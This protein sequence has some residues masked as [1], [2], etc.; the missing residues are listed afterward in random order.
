MLQQLA[1]GV[2]A[3]NKHE[4][5][6][7]TNSDAVVGYIPP[8]N[9]PMIEDYYLESRSLV[10]VTKDAT[11]DATLGSANYADGKLTYSFT[12]PRTT[13]VILFVLLHAL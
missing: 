9:S 5:H 4:F 13:S 6:S 3:S 10:G 11:N 8:S 1:N 7:Q 12:R 2:V